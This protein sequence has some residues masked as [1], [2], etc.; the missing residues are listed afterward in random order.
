M[1]RAHDSRVQA[2]LWGVAEARR[3]HGRE[4]QESNGAGPARPSPGRDRPSG[5]QDAVRL[6]LHAC[7]TGGDAPVPPARPVPGW[8]REGG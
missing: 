3:R 8:D 6:L 2:L 4:R 5:P 7:W 1:D